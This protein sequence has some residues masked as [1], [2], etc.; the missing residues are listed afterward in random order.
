MTTRASRR[1]FL[2][3]CSLVSIAGAASPFALNL[4]AIS[5]ASA[6]TSPG[7]KALVC[8][9][10]YGGKDHTNTLIPYDPTSS[11]GVSYDPYFASQ[12]TIATPYPQ[13]AA[14]STRS[15]ASRD[16]HS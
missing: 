9:F 16:G 6:T 15:G 14:T 13:L 11:D 7:Y 1:Q 3:T 4:A 12:D 10:F 5:A 2:R 8:L